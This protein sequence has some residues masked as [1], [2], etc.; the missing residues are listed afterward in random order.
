MNPEPAYHAVLLAPSGEAVRPLHEG[1][2]E[3]G[4]RVTVTDS[5]DEAR[6]RI[7]SGE[8]DLVTAFLASL[9]GGADAG[10][11]LLSADPE[12]YL[13][14]AAPE[15]R[16]G[17][18]LEAGGAMSARFLPWPCSAWTLKTILDGARSRIDMERRGDRMKEL[19][20]LWEIAKALSSGKGSET[21]LEMILDSA[22]RVTGADTGS[23]MLVKPGGD[24][25]TIASSRGLSSEVV[26]NAKVKVGEG[27]AGWVA[28]EGEP[29]LL[30]E[31]H[32]DF[33]RFRDFTQRNYIRSSVCV[34]IKSTDA[35]I[36]GTLSLN[37]EKGPRNFTPHELQLMTIY[38][39]EAGSVI[40]GA[41]GAEEKARAHDKLR[42]SHER[43]KSIQ[44]Q[45]VQSGK[46]AAVGMLASGVA[47][48]FN[49]LLTGILGMAQLAQTSGKERHVEKALRVAI[50]NS[51]KAKAVVKNLLKF[52]SQFKKVREKVDLGELADEVLSLVSRELEKADVELVRNYRDRPKVRV[53]RGEIQQ[54]LLNLV[55]NARQAMEPEGGRL[56]IALTHKPPVARIAVKDTGVG[57]PQENLPRIFEPFFSTKSLLGGGGSSQGSGLG[58]SVGYG[59]VKGHGGN[60]L[61]ESEPD[62]GTTF[63]VELPLTPPRG[64][65]YTDRKTR[66]RVLTL[67]PGVGRAA[68]PPE[69]PVL[70]VDDEAW[71]REFLKETLAEAGLETVLAGD[72]PEGLA[73]FR[74]KRPGLVFVDL[75]MP[76]MKGQD[77]CRTMIEERPET[78][79]V[80]MSGK[81]EPL[82]VIEKELERGVHAYLRKPFEVQDV[83]NILEGGHPG[84]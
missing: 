21:L 75:V 71:V 33:E 67:P 37:H 31:G 64:E 29:L 47:H 48:E 4:F 39:A 23:V 76:G 36:M 13:L 60:L 70:V 81:L 12:V 10:E 5:F 22:M 1:L 59:I 46:M 63:T 35:E 43:L 57:I 80:L 40:Q 34:P 2:E 72:G 11:R 27:I 49:N 42:T 20:E 82:D 58:L 61:V 79:I 54:V 3:S 56:E 68:P 53:N 66:T 51:E 16:G 30:R 78:K 19:V 69:G 74:E 50:S 83:F 17:E 18:A 77:L 65:E 55:L 14:I 41:R 8:V 24:E 73:L 32:R 52:S 6:S 38:A 7:A 44:A 28:L 26:Q 15:E 9:A 84:P 25:M 62:R 45:L